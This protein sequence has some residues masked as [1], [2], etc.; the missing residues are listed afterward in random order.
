MI[1]LKVNNVEVNAHSFYNE[2]EAAKGMVGGEYSFKKLGV[3][4][5]GE[6]EI[7][8]YDCLDFTIYVNGSKKNYFDIS[9]VMESTIE[10][11]IFENI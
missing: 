8:D 5:S 9:D 11:L 7:H 1:K 6:F 3:E 4:I 2:D 10:T